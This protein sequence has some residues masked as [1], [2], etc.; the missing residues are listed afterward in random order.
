MEHT[1]TSKDLW[2]IHPQFLTL[3]SFPWLDTSVQWFS[4]WAARQ[5]QIESQKNADVWPHNREIQI[6][7][8]WWRAPTSIFLQSSPGNSSAQSRSRSLA[9]VYLAWS[10]LHPLM[11]LTALCG[12]H[13]SQHASL[14][15]HPA[16]PRIWALCLSLTCPAEQLQLGVTFY[17]ML[18]EHLYYFILPV[19]LSPSFGY[20]RTRSVPYPFVFYQALV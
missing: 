16:D 1:L 4:T 6:E 2:C 20:S 15:P 19:W 7:L 8:F 18:P 14:L 3:C 12:L 9:L 5:S 11:L 13:A 10:Q 17:L